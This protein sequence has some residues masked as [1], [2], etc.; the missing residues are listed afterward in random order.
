MVGL[1]LKDGMAS[2][3][4]RAGSIYGE[5]VSGLDMKIGESITN[6]EID[7][8]TIQQEKLTMLTQSGTYLAEAAESFTVFAASF[9]AAPVVMVTPTT[10]VGG[11][12]VFT[13]VVKAGSFGTSGG[14]AHTGNYIAWGPQ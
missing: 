5:M 2:T 10:D 7:D 8:T 13:S 1:G 12:G 3:E 14:A 6:A 4:V 11:A 9:G